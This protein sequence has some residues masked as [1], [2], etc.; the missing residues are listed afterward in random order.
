MQILTE[1]GHFVAMLV[2]KDFIQIY[3]SLCHAKKSSSVYKTFYSHKSVSYRRIYN[4]FFYTRFQQFLETNNFYNKENANHYNKDYTVKD[5][6]MTL[7]AH[8]SSGPK[9]EE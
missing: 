6:H 5:I 2:L 3:I 8:D 1:S 7:G 4:F 9:E